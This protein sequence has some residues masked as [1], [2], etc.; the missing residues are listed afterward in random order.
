MTRQGRGTR[1]HLTQT[2]GSSLERGKRGVRGRTPVSQARAL[3]RTG[4]GFFV[5]STRILKS[6][7]ISRCCVHLTRSGSCDVGIDIS[8]TVAERPLRIAVK[9]F[10]SFW[11]NK[12]W[13]SKVEVYPLERDLRVY[14]RKVPIY[15]PFDLQVRR[16]TN[17][18]I[19]IS[20]PLHSIG[21]VVVLIIIQMKKRSAELT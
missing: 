20:T 7:S 21:D 3:G 19:P 1:S 18:N 2:T 8:P 15:G 5:S 10:G 12:R 9:P 4:R 17:G 6:L 13:W 16:R 11:R 14:T